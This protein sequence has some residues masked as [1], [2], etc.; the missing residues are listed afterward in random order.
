MGLQSLASSKRNK[1]LFWYQMDMC[2]S[3]PSTSISKWQ[4]LIIPKLGEP[5]ARTQSTFILEWI[6]CVAVGQK[7]K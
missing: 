2:E 3:V 1:V 5:A 6:L 7:V 4:G